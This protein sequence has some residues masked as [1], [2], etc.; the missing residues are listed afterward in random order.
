MNE[1]VHDVHS[2]FGD[3]NIWVDLFQNFVDV[4]REGL[5]SSSSGFLFSFSSCL[6][7]GHFIQTIKLQTQINFLNLM[8]L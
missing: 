4:D 1:R 5:N 2:L 6:S 7:L 3:T 8:A